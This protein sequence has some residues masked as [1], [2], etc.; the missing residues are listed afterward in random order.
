MDAERNEEVQDSTKDDIRALEVETFEVEEM[1]DLGAY[2]HLTVV[3]TSSTTS[4]SCG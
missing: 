1:N 4:S 2:A 3:T